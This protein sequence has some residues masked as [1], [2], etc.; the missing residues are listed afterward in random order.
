MNWLKRSRSGIGLKSSCDLP[1]IGVEVIVQSAF[2]M[3]LEHNYQSD[4]RHYQCGDDGE[5]ASNKKPKPQRMRGHS[6]VFRD[7]VSKP[8]SRFNE[9]PTHLFTNACNENFH[10]VGCLLIG[11]IDVLDEFRLRHDLTA[12]VHQ[13]CDKPIFQR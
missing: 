9:A 2:N 4:A 12:L 6:D 3:V 1:D 8:S 7:E 11:A 10:R 13:I 5:A